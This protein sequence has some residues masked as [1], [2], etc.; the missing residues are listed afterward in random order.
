MA[1]KDNGLPNSSVIFG[2]S[3]DLT[4]RKLIPSLFNLFCKGRMPKEFRIVGFGGTA[5]TDD[6]FRTH[7]Q[8]GMKE[9]SDTKFTDQDWQEFA[10]H[11]AYVKHGYAAQDFKQL[12]EFLNQWQGD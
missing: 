6:T 8:E 3:G 10:S 5:F 7:L 2:S 1:G 11:L 4:Q 9:F 12:D